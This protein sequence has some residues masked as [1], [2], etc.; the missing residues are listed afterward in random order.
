[1]LS[2]FEKISLFS[3]HPTT[4]GNYR[5][6]VLKQYLRK[7]TPDNL[8]IGS[9]FIYDHG[10]AEQD[11]L[12]AQQ[13]KQIDC[14]IYDNRNYTPFLK[15]AD[16]VIIDPRALFA[17][18][19]VKS[20]LT[21]YKEFDRTNETVSD[22]YPLK[23]NESSPYRWAGTMVEALINIQSLNK[24]SSEYNKSYF[25]G[26]FAYSSNFDF[27]NLLFAFDNNELQNQLGISHISELPTYICIPG[28]RLVYFGKTSIFAR[29]EDG[30]DP[31]ETEMTVIENTEGNQAF[32]LQFFSNALKVQLDHN[33][34][35]KSPDK[36]GLFTAGTGVV[37]HWGGHFRL[38]S[39]DIANQNI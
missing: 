21:F 37:K 20:T 18:I 26:V 25:R 4:L 16:F 2:E 38:H 23:G 34:F 17:G 15:A 29:E 11:K 7:F 13:T 8:A 3:K 12:Y 1:M 39:E 35:K 5:E 19:E 10:N 27:N 14:L 30:F 9:G 31:Y 6:Q 24:V 36:R 33:L 28:D 32:A 22:K